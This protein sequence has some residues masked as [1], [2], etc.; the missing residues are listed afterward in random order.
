MFIRQLIIAVSGHSHLCLSPSHTRGNLLPHHNHTFIKITHERLV[1]DAG[2]AI[3]QIFTLL[4]VSLN[5]ICTFILAPTLT[6][7]H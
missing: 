3:T 2:D 6:L 1:A 4:L 7:N 5:L